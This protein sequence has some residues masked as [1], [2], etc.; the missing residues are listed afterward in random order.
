[1]DD[2]V[3]VTARVSH[4]STKVPLDGVGVASYR[5][6]NMAIN[7]HLR[8]ASEL[9]QAI[10][11]GRRPFNVDDRARIRSTH[12]INAIDRQEKTSWKATSELKEGPMPS[13]KCT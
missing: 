12:P 3:L 11:G 6:L 2:V 8:Y 10:G 9:S 4:L 13:A 1:M 7:D 5:I